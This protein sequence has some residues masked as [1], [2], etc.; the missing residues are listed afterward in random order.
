MLYVLMKIL[1]HASAKK[2]TKTFKGFKICTFTGR[3]QVTSYG[4]KGVN[5]EIPL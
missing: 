4:S 3:F 2:K 5:K 1:S